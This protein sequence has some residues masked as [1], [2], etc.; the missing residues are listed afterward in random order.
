MAFDETQF[1]SK[2]RSSS[3]E[4][5]GSPN[6]VKYDCTCKIYGACFVVQDKSDCIKIFKDQLRISYFEEFLN[7]P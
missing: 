1:H 3:Q 2:R 7:D 5:K 6:T 4:L